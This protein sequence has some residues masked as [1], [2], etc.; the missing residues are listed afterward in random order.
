MAEVK[1]EAEVQSMGTEVGT[2]KKVGVVEAVGTAEVI[3]AIWAIEIVGF[4]VEVEA[5]T[6]KLGVET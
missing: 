5:S 4:E 3:G 2:V 6:S 1:V